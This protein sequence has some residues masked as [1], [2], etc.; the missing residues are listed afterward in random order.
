MKTRLLLVTLLASLFLTGGAVAQ[1]PGGKAAEKSPGDLAADAFYKVYGDKEAKLSQERFGQVITAGFAYL[2]KFPTHGRANG[3][4]K[5]LANFGDSIKDPK[6]KAY[7]SA[8]V[9]QLKFQV[10]DQRYK[11][12]VTDDAKAAL[13]ALEAAAVDFE[14]R[15]A[16][17][18]DAINQL[19]EK[20]DA[21]AA[22]PGGLRYLSDREKSYAEILSRG[23]S[24]AAGEAHLN[25]LLKHA[26]KGIAGM[27]RTELNMV[28]LKKAPYEL[29]FTAFDGKPV[30]VAALRGKVVVMV[31]WSGQSENTLKAIDAVKQAQSFFKKSVEVIGVSFDKE[32]DREKVTKFIKD[33]KI[34]W[35]V[36]YDGKEAKNEWAPKMNLPRLPVIVVF[37][38]KG[39]FVTN[40]LPV[41]QVEGAVKKL[42]EAK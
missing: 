13:A 26:D 35:P 7:R 30:D 11:E 8:Y 2:I 33:N 18:R 36:H 37:D 21:L 9:T 41:A 40:N 42:S 17:S 23:V 39:M 6:L 31:I 27:A 1:A 28:E 10:V 15:D 12:G 25:K 34:T 14:T 4:I 20:I 38:K 22:A 32:A 29:K 16:P 5:D 24:P 3:V 19:R